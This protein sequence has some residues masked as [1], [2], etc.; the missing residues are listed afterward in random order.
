MAGMAGDLVLD[1]DWVVIKGKWTKLATLD[2]MLDAPSRRIDQSGQRRAL[3]HDH[4][5]KL[6]INYSGD[7]PN[8]VHIAGSTTAESLFVRH[9]GV[10]AEGIVTP[11]ILLGHGSPPP[12]HVPGGPPG[13][14]IEWGMDL[15]DAIATL[16]QEV[17]TLQAEL[18]GVKRQLPERRP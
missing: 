14:G 5:D 6:T 13:G 16:Q 10:F 3:V 18:E 11:K 7:Y 9:R 15:G 12:T 1:G 2:L 8:G 4:G 17:A